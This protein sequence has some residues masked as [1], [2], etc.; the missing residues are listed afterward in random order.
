MSRFNIAPQDGDLGP[1][2]R[3][4]RLRGERWQWEGRHPSNWKLLLAS[5][6][7]VSS[8]QTPWNRRGYGSKLS[9]PDPKR[10]PLASRRASKVLSLTHGSVFLGWLG[11]PFWVG[12][13]ANERETEANLWARIA[14][15]K[16]FKGELKGNQSDLGGLQFLISSP[17]RAGT[18]AV[19]TAPGDLCVKI[20]KQAPCCFPPPKHAQGLYIYIYIY[21]LMYTLALSTPYP[22]YYHGSAQGASQKGQLSSK[23]LL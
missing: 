9:A 22:P 1:R 13:K 16:C 12:S 15:V 14:T 7:G 4:A 8:L 17:G 21:M 20:P 6:V 2:S 11:T 3:T 18:A 10:A 23:A 5:V 19:E